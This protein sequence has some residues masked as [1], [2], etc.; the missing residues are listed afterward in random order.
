MSQHVFLRGMVAIRLFSALAEL[1][2]AL[3][4]WR[5]QRLETAVRING[6]LGLVGPLVLTT[7]MALGLAGLAQSRLPAA[8]LVWIG[9]GVG[10]ILWGTRR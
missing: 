4:M 7:T 9:A 3:L 8:R 5:F 6:L 2:G 1:T 10:L